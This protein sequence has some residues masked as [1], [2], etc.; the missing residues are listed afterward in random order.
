VVK[1]KPAGSRGRSKAAERG[2]GKSRA[3]ELI[4][5]VALLIEYIMYES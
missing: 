5:I 4:E 2:W 1:V 3:T